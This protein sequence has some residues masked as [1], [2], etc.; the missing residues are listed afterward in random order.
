M[1]KIIGITLIVLFLVSFWVGLSFVFYSAGLSLPWSITIPFLCYVG[2]VL[3]VG[4]T[5]LVSW[6]LL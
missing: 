5:E 1:K 6:L 4:F 2:A 3:I